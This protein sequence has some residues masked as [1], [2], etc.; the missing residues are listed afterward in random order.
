[1][2]DRLRESFFEK[3]IFSLRL[4]GSE[5]LIKILNFGFS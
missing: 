4:K 5:E 2:I 1:M 3:L